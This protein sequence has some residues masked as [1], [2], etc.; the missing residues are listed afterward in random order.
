M[1]LFPS[2]V[3][4]AA[5]AGLLIL[6]AAPASAQSAAAAT[7]LPPTKVLDVRGVRIGE[8][9][10]KT[11]VPITAA[12]A[13]EAL[14]Q[15][16]RIAA[17]ADTDIAEWRIDYL[18]I[19]LDRKAL[20]RLGPQVAKALHGKPLLLTFRTKAEGGAKPIADADY[21]KLYAT[22]LKTRFADLLDVEM[23]RDAAVVQALVAQA[24]AAGVAVVMSS[25]DFERTP[26]TAEIVARLQ[27]QQALGADVLKIAVMPHDAG[28][29]LKLL[30]ATW[31]LRRRNDRP[32]LTMAMGGT[33]VVSRL[34]GETFGQVLTFGMLGKASA[35]GQVEV[36]RLRE[37]LDTIHQAASAAR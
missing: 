25:H 8:G 24:H 34:S 20:A 32:L 11:I 14:A 4:A 29:V 36:G 33:G 12:T 22:L 6:A 13:D 16:A 1:T 26:D 18:D 28:D 37:V 23:F 10:P 15:A 7:T 31:Q 3:C 2:R 9:A 5:L 30:D 21:G 35:P 17:N 19:A 27:R